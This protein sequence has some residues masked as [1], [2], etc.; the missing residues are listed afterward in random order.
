[1]NSGVSYLSYPEDQPTPPY[2]LKPDNSYFLIVLHDVQAY[3]DAGFGARPRYLTISSSVDG[4]FLEQA[5]QSLHQVTTLQKNVPTR[6]GFRSNLTD[7]L[8]ARATDSVKLT[9][10]Y[11]VARD[12]P[13]KN[14]VDR[15][16]QVDLVAKLTLIR[17]DLAVAAKVSQIAGKLLSF[18]MQE[19]Q[20]Q[21]IFGLTAD[22]NVQEM[23]AGY[24]TIFSSG[25][26]VSK[27]PTNVRIDKQGRLSGEQYLLDRLNY[28]VFKVLALPRRG[29]EIARNEA[30]W[31]LLQVA[32]RK[33]LASFPQDDAERRQLLVDWHAALSDVHRMANEN[34]N[35]YLLV[36]I[37]QLITEAEVEVKEYLFPGT[38]ESE[39][40]L[41]PKLQEVLGLRSEQELY[42]SLRDYHDAL[43]ASRQLV[44]LYSEA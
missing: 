35:G 11:I 23:T 13:F 17:M 25:E 22:F 3:F 5:T 12:T 29:E 30:W 31:E 26:P 18:L 10:K 37:R 4:S 15:M 9:L 27:W 2:T 7:W 20:S 34:A 24:Y 38:R 40:E 32:K 8:P 21:D 16:E 6:I 14:L 19:G 1:M 33:A 28:A 39:Q 41:P 43:E 36:E 42:D 44:T